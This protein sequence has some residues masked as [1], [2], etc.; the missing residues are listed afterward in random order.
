[1]RILVVSVWFP[2]PATN[3]SKLR[4]YGLL[5]YLGAR[6]DVALLTFAEPGEAD[7]DAVEHLHSF[8]RSVRVQEG[9]PHKVR[10]PLRA[11]DLLQPVPRSYVSTFDASMSALVAE[12]LP[13]CDVVV[14]LEVGGAV[15]VRPHTGRPRV[16]EE[17][18][19]TIIRERWLRSKSRDRLR[20]GLTWWKTAR[21]FRRL[22][23][24]FD[25]TTVVSE[26]ERQT[27]LFVGC[28]ASRISVVPNAVDGIL[29][30]GALPARVPG[31]LVY[32]GALT[33]EANL[34][35]VR[36][37]V[38]DILPRVQVSQPRA[39]LW[40]TGGFERADT[41][42]IA[43][44][45]GVVLTGFIADIRSAVGS[46]EA[47]VVPLRVGGGTRLKVLE[48]M[49]A[50][51]PVVSTSK[52]IEGLDVVHG[53]DVLVADDP[54]AFAAHVVRVLSDRGLADGLAANGRTRVEQLYTWA[55]SGERLEE[56]IALAID[57]FG[58]RRAPRSRG[59]TR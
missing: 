31:R 41:T 26:L 30:P 51:T 3:G 47:C 32:N 25:H 13:G 23:D 37:F 2:Y 12:S 50:G 44:R 39:H 6:H 34:D 35:A 58:A 18:E 4:A 10:Q 8:C 15:H 19:V 40:V 43:D 56:A 54:S 28:E 57:R 48:A 36:F 7:A 38:R 9:N 21:F 1:V 17:A 11:R 49:A 27:L 46:S 5:R 29:A 22:V 52:G 20:A 45:P 59:A 14:A 42:G 16:F 33:Y 24:E 53:R 55:R